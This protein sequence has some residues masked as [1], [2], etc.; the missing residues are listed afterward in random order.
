MG[1]CAIGARFG[2]SFFIFCSLIIRNPLERGFQWIVGYETLLAVAAVTSVASCVCTKFAC[3]IETH[4]RMQ[5]LAL[6]NTSKGETVAVYREKK[7]STVSPQDD[8][9]A[10]YGKRAFG[11]LQDTPFHPRDRYDAPNSFWC[12]LTTVALAYNTAHIALT[13]ASDPEPLAC[14]APALA[15]YWCVTRSAQLALS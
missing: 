8:D 7:L 1:L 10:R 5:H 14:G 12:A 13:D 9:A 4:R 15:L 11:Q 2:L 3:L 6:S